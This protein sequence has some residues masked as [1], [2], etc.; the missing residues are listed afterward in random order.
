[1]GAPI[2]PRLPEQ[3]RRQNPGYP[4]L[5]P[6]SLP[7]QPDLGDL[8]AAAVAAAAE[9]AGPAEGERAGGGG[10][11]GNIG[12][13]RRGGGRFGEVGMDLRAVSGRQADFAGPAAAVISSTN[14]Q[15]ECALWYNGNRM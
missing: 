1:V 8:A 12:L 7:N 15:S 2:I 3:A 14:S 9:L 13:L 4:P 5:F 11:R 10:G 6:S